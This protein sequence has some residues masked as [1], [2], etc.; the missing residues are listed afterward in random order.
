MF[1]GVAAN[2]VARHE[3]VLNDNADGDERR[4]G[5]PAV[6]PSHEPRAMCRFVW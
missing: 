4:Q 1:S 6:H 2:V 5:P 3:A